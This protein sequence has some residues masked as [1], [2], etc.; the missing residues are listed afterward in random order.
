METSLPPEQLAANRK[1]SPNQD[2]HQLGER[3]AT[4]DL[5][6]TQEAL[7][8]MLTKTRCSTL[9]RNTKHQV[10]KRTPLQTS[11]QDHKLEGSNR[12]IIQSITTKMAF[13]SPTL[14]K[15]AQAK[16][17]T[18]KITCQTSEGHTTQ[19]TIFINHLDT[20]SVIESKWKVLALAEPLASV[21]PDMREWETLLE[22]LES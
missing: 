12:F 21:H 16:Q 20:D 8:F 13:M 14:H 18:C 19:T 7:M 2:N 9:S 10:I 4:K 11:H 1:S 22:W 15:L 5:Q 3:E 17:A 6:L